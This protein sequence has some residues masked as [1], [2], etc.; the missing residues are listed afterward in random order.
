LVAVI[1]VEPELPLCVVS[2]ALG[3][4]VPVS[5][6]V[7]TAVGRNFTEQVAVPVVALA[8]S[9]QLD[10]ENP[11]EPE[12]VNATVPAGVLTFAGL[13]SF[14]VTVQEVSTLSGRLLGEQLIVVEVPRLLTVSVVL[15]ELWL[16]DV[17]DALGV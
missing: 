16:C 10:A 11:P 1:V 6:A 13:V 2:L 3:V 17:S 12:W 15:P 5:V 8:V 9:V 4:N 7:S 14:T